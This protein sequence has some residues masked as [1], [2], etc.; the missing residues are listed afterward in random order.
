MSVQGSVYAF[1]MAGGVGSRLWPRS[2]RSQPKQFLDLVRQET[3]LQESF[4]RLLPIIPAERILVGVGTQY[5]PIVRMQLPDLPP[6]N[7]VV[8]PAGRGTAPAIGLGALH[9]HRR[10]PE[11]VMAV[12]TAD[13]HIGDA[14][15]FRRALMAAAEMARAGQ[16]ITM[17][18]TPTFASTGYGYIRRGEKLDTVDGFDIYRALRFTEKP[19][20]TLAQA[21]LE[22][23]LYSWNSGMFVWQTKA[24]RAELERQMPELHAQL[25]QIEQALGTADEGTVLERVWADVSK[26]TIDY[27]VME[28]APEVAVIPVQIGWND[29]GSWQTLMELLETDQDGNLLTGEHIALDTQNT[30]IYSPT[31]LVATIGLEDMIVVDTPDAL[32]ICPRDRCQDVRRIVDILRQSGQEDLL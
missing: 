12:V 2:R 5:V 24:I 27:G 17:G 21:F 8:E 20:T 3:M 14:P 30:L 18:I 13:H 1:I 9:I 25:G 31:K 15:H 32:L 29:I 11:A 19:D 4:D 22:S 16:L 6:E 26:Q 28:H 7:I 10:D 23:G